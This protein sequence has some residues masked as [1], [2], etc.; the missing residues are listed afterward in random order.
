MS[1]E[2]QTPTNSEVEKKETEEEEGLDEEVFSEAFQSIDKETTEDKARRLKDSGNLFLQK[3]TR[4]KNRDYFYTAIQHYTE[5][6]E[7]KPKDHELISLLY[8]NRAAVNL[9]LANHGRVVDDATKAIE[10]NKKN[11]KAYYRLT[12]AALALHRYEVA[13]EVAEKGLEVDGANAELKAERDKAKVVVDR[14]RA[15]EN[16]KKKEIKERGFII[17]KLEE[18]KYRI[19]KPVLCVDTLSLI[20]I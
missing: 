13:L 6:L 4:L 11:V 20:H 9:I 18:R 19:G 10:Y 8:S 16:A 1:E 2:K 7:M 14:K 15:E 17:K 3:A 5:A 12:K